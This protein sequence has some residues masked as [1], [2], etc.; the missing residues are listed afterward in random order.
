MHRRISIRE[1]PLIG[2][3]LAIWMDVVRMQQEFEL[4]LGEVRI[5]QN[6][7]KAVKSQ[8]PAGVPGVLPLV[9]HRDDV[10]IDHMKPVGV[11]DRDDAPCTVLRQPARDIEVIVLLTP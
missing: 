1:G 6:Q 11:A 5:D 7:R 9:R 3:K 2:R 10:V 8:V 4:L